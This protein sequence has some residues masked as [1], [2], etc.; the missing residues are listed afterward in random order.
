M[1]NW[2][3]VLLINEKVI[4]SITNIS[5]NVSDGYLLP[6]IKLS[7]DIDLEETIGTPLKVAL[8]QKVYNNEIG[9]DTQYKALLDDYIQ[10]YLAYSTIVHLIPT[11]AW[12]IGNAGIMITDD[13]KMT[14]TN[15]IDKVKNHYKHLA[16]VYK[17][18]LQRHLVA[19]YSKYP[20]L[21]KYKSCE[22]IRANLY[23]SASCGLNLG[24]PRGKKM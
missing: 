17:N 21:S 22:D 19:N 10:P 24:G 11:V 1:A 7:Q 4:K 2:T 5:E 13:E 18:R 16:D 6:S 3:D 12:K 8:Q 14:N 20:E 15:D 23:S 9:G